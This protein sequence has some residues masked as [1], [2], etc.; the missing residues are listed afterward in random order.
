MPRKKKEEAPIRQESVQK[1][2]LE[3]IMA[4]RF[5]RYSK[6]IIQERALP[7]ARDGLKPVQRRILYAMYEAK[8]TF[9]HPYHKSAKTVGNVIGNYHPHGDTSVYD[10]M[11]RMSQDWKITTPL[12]DMQGNNGSIDDDPAAAMRYTEA[13]LAKI[14]NY[15]L[16]DIDR[17]TVEWAPN[18]SDEKMEPTVLPA[19]FP[20][21]LINGISGIAAGYAT[22]IPP[23]NLNEIVSACIYRL[24]NPECTLDEIMQ[25]VKGP[26]FPTGGIVMGEKGIREAFETGRGK[27]IVRSKA[28]IESTRTIDQIVVSEIPYEVIKSNLV[29]KID[30]I[31]LNR[32][33][34]G[35]LDVRDESDRNGLR[36]VIDVKKGAPTDTILNYLYKNTELQISFNYNVIAIV[37]KTPVQLGLIQ[38]IDAFLEHR[39]DVVLKR[40]RYDLAVK[41]ERAHILDGLM[42][43]VS[44]MDEI[45]AIIRK[46]KDK[47]DSK[48]NLID[49]FHFSELQAEAI[50]NMRLYRLSN[51]D[52]KELQREDRQLKKEIKA[53]EAILSKETVRNQKIIEELEEVNREFVVP[54]RSLIE[55]EVQEIV[56]DEMAMIP[57]EQVMVCVTRDG[58]I[59]RVSIRSFNASSELFAGKKDNDIMVASGEIN[60]KDKVLFFTDRGK[61]GYIP[62]HQIDEAKWKDLGSHISNYIRIDDNEKVIAAFGVH[63]FYKESHVIM[64]SQAGSIKRSSLAAFEVSRPNRTMVCMKIGELDALESVQIS[65]SEKDQIFLAS[66]HGFGL[67]YSADQVPENGM[68]TKGVKG[69][70][71]S[72][73]DRIA[74]M[75]VAKEASQVFLVLKEGMIKRMHTSEIASA[76]RPA[77]GSRLYKLVK[78]HPGIVSKLLNA[79]RTY[80]FVDD[81]KVEFKPADISLMNAQSTYSAPFGKVEKMEWLADLPMIEQGTWP[82]KKEEFEQA[83]LI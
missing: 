60:T 33:V 32:K 56:I 31:R 27:V 37:N 44:V 42:I 30:E 2:A 40:S 64:A 75:L 41:Q 55:N 73:D 51:T 1:L 21:L 15:M 61:Y 47:K 3:D 68:K 65:G 9:D 14:S 57:S 72:A 45:I 12:V 59:K 28:V 4:D 66:S 49:R 69:M 13:G 54:R 6:Y 39:E 5:G 17:K 11:V 76:S 7:D 34:D 83:T 20:N 8:N 26:D 63:E 19:R 43:A 10:A 35:I 36:I 71:L 16:A 62:V 38:A 58:Y 80:T 82:E 18:F 81:E 74:A 79:D 25:I 53:L 48:I 22:N 67:Q 46:S 29:K 77:K 52:V 23:H 24:Q 50:V 70:N 78:S